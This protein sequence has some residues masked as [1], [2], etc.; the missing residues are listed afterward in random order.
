MPEFT[1]LFI[2]REPRHNANSGAHL[3]VEVDCPNDPE[4]GRLPAELLDL[5]RNGVKL[6]VALPINV[7]ELVHIHLRHPGSGLT[8]SVPT[9]V[10]WRR[11][12]DDDNGWFLGCRH[13]VEIPMETL[14]ELFLNE[15]LVIDA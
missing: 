1:E 15:I 2:A 6:C 5:S 4:S 13:T 12:A 10:R 14:G 9:T 11:S 7:G 3:D 8:V